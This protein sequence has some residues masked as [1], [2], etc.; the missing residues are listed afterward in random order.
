MYKQI[1]MTLKQFKQDDS[2]LNLESFIYEQIKGV[3]DSVKLHVESG[4]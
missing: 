2:K 1:R 3:C 4:L